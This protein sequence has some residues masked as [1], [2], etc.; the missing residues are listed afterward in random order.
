MGGLLSSPRS[1]ERGSIEARTGPGLAHNSRRT[2]HVRLN[3]ALLKPHDDAGF[4]LGSN[5]SPRSIERGSIEAWS[6][7]RRADSRPSLSTFD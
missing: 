5:D 6:R 2:L 4:G 1:I 3:V 7:M